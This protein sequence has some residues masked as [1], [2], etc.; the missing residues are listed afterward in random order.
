MLHRAHA[1]ARQGL[2][3]TVLGLLGMVALVV[4][5][6]GLAISGGGVGWIITAAV[7]AGVV[8]LAYLDPGGH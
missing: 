3:L 6:V 2:G 1:P 8:L 7:A 5:L 4:A